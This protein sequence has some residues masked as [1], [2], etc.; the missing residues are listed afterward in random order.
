MVDPG[1]P[2]QRAQLRGQHGV[3]DPDL[4]ASERPGASGRFEGYAHSGAALGRV[5]TAATGEQ[6]HPLPPSYVRKDVQGA[7]SRPA[8]PET[9]R[10]HTCR[11]LSPSR[12]SPPA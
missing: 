10:E 2:G 5:D 8:G 11:F 3:P 12:P 4:E 6:I 7:V 1:R 9:T